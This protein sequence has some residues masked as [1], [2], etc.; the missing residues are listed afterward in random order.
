ML[1]V[2][3][4]VGDV[5]ELLG[6]LLAK[7]KVFSKA[8]PMGRLFPRTG[9]YGALGASSGHRVCDG[10]GE[11]RLDE[12]GLLEAARHEHAKDLCGPN[13]ETV[14]GTVPGLVAHLILA[15]H[16]GHLDGPRHCIETARILLDQL[17]L[18]LA[19]ILLQP[20][21]ALALLPAAGHRV[22]ALL[23]RAPSNCVVLQLLLL[24]RGG[25][26]GARAR[27]LLLLVG[28][29]LRLGL[30]ESLRMSRLRAG[31]LVREGWAVRAGRRLLELR[32]P[33]YAVVLQVLQLE[34]LL[35][36]AARVP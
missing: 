7:L 19:E 16:D 18:V 34:L 32:A 5:H 8:V 10:R 15:L 36:G 6:K 35:L 29:R 12:G 2:L 26:V 23:G 3:Q 14:N 11:K 13:A 9:A 22:G 1:H 25:P 24:L 31:R 17:L 33:A 28:L 21:Q 27:Q 4:L 20:V 30:C